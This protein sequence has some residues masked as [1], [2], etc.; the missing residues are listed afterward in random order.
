MKPG[1]KARQTSITPPTR[2]TTEAAMLAFLRIAA[3]YSRM[4]ADDRAGIA[5]GRLVAAVAEL[6][7][8]AFHKVQGRCA[9]FGDVPALDVH[10]ELAALL[11]EVSTGELLL[12]EH[13]H[14]EQPG[15]PEGLAGG[16]DTLGGRRDGFRVDLTE[17]V[18]R[19][20]PA[21][22]SMAQFINAIVGVFATGDLGVDA[23]QV[24]RYLHAELTYRRPPR[25]AE[26]R[27]RDWI[28]QR[29]RRDTAYAMISALAGVSRD[30]LGIVADALGTEGVAD[31][32]D[33]M[34]SDLQIVDYVREVLG[35]GEGDRAAVRRVLSPLD[36]PETVPA[37]VPIPP[38]PPPLP[39]APKYVGSPAGLPSSQIGGDVRG[40][41]EDGPCEARGDDDG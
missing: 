20:G 35:F 13:E 32:A 1:G 36:E 21:R 16:F 11:G 25:D 40:T 5:L 14:E 2:Q 18:A 10:A 3:R 12:D 7:E 4:G 27:V 34:E 39:G 37:A 33:P 31:D 9:R 19:G 29:G 38:A 41:D 6:P 26:H 17:R 8:L 24:E 28:R 23:E 22:M 30:R 15:E